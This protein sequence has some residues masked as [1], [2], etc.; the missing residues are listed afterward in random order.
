MAVGDDLDLDVPR[1]DDLRLQEHG[2]IAEGPLGLGARGLEGVGELAL[3]GHA[4]DAAAAA[5]GAGLDH[6]RVAEPLGVLPSLGD[7][8]HWPAAPGRDRHAGGLGQPLGADLVAEPA[9][10]LAA[11]TDEGHAEPGAQIGERGVL[12]HEAPADPGGVGAGPTQ[13]VGEAVEVEVGAGRADEVALVSLADE[14]GAT[15]GLGVERDGA[16]PGELAGRDDEAHG[17]LAAVHDRDAFEH[18]HQV[19]A[20][21]SGARS[22]ASTSP[23]GVVRYPSSVMNTLPPSSMMR[24]SKAPSLRGVTT[25]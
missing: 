20:A 10:D 6:E 14:H 24:A 18:R 1:A 2:G 15:V 19:T 21:A 13:R 12:G 23:T 11:R 3:R 8:S 5:A 4:A 22:A 16:R 7:R 9:H 17:R 25:A